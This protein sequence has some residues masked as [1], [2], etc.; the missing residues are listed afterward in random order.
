M[1]AIDH[2]GQ[3]FTRLTV[4]RLAARRVRGQCAWV[5]RCD[6]GTMKM[7]AGTEL[8]SGD[9]QSCG[10]L[11]KERNTAFWRANGMPDRSSGSYRTWRC[12]RARCQPNHPRHADYFDRGITICERWDNFA[13]FLADM[14]ERP[15][16]FTI[17]RIDNDA[18]YSPQNCRWATRSEQAQNR[19]P[20]SGVR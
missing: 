7:V 4:E 3:R 20:K 16:G 1:H 19:R 14:G 6:C 9:T 18:G 13:N 17:E 5:C 12:M 10:C 15:N 11:R 8:R 2:T